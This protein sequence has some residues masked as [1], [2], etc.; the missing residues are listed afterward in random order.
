MLSQ[1]NM[2]PEV[3]RPL[4]P[5]KFLHKRRNLFPLS[6]R[7]SFGKSDLGLQ[8]LLRLFFWVAAHISRAVIPTVPRL[9]PVLRRQL[10]ILSPPHQICRRCRSNVTP[11]CLRLIRVEVRRK[12][13]RVGEG[14]IGKEVEIGEVMIL[15]QLVIES[16]VGRHGQG[17]C[18]WSWSFAI[19]RGLLHVVQCRSKAGVCTIPPVLWSPPYRTPLLPHLN[20]STR[21]LL[22]AAVV[23]FGGAEAEAE[24]EAES[25]ACSARAG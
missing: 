10:L 20:C 21:S 13:I 16:I 22:C 1:Y 18:A 23:E 14:R 3:S 5:A 4:S 25:G 8:I 7:I 17:R 6:L 12:G 9:L 19:R 11:V 15:W 24:A 2:S